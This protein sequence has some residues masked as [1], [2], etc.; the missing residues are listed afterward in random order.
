MAKR[1]GGTRRSEGVL[2]FGLVCGVLEVRWRV[3]VACS[4]SP[5]CLVLCNKNTFFNNATLC[6]V[7]MNPSNTS[8]VFLG[9][10]DEAD[11]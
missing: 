5:A 3:R 9:A 8:C 7:G 1:F 6:Y 2:V 10:L 4:D 11:G